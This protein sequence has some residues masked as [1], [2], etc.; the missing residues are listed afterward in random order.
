MMMRRRW[1][2]LRQQLRKFLS[3]HIM[4]QLLSNQVTQLWKR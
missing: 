1:H 4:H 2:R 3:S